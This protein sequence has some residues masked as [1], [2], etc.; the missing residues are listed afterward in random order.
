M[1]IVILKHT[2]AVSAGRGRKMGT[3]AQYGV[4]EDNGAEDLR[5]I[6]TFTLHQEALEVSGTMGWKII[7]D[8]GE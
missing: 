7:E 1:D 6:A 4:Y 2:R 5:H 3:A 8:E